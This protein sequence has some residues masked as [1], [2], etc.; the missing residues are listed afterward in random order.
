MNAWGART[1]RTIER[2][3]IYRGHYADLQERNGIACRRKS[4]EAI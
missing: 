1:M 4:A 2:D 3:A